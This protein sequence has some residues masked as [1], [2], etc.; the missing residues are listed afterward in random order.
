MS[1]LK[2]QIIRIIEHYYV[3]STYQPSVIEIVNKILAIPNLA[4]L[5][6]DQELPYIKYGAR[7]NDSRYTDKVVFHAKIEAQKDMLK[8]GFRRV[9]NAY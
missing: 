6:K 4:E 7:L 2:E 3:S 8:T 5:D 1:S 9:R